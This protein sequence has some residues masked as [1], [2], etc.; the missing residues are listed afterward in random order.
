MEVYFSLPE[1]CCYKLMLYTFDQDPDNN[2]N[3]QLSTLDIEGD[4]FTSSVKY[5][6]HSDEEI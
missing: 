4:V 1:L 2:W 5:L 3:I 6:S